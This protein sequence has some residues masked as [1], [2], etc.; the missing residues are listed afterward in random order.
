MRLRTLVRLPLLLAAIVAAMFALAGAASAAPASHGHDSTSVKIKG[1]TTALTLDKGT[2]AVLTKNKVTVKP[3]FGAK[4]SGATL[5]FPIEGGKVD[6]KTLAGKIQHDGG[7]RFSAGGKSL[8]V[9]EFEIDTKAG[10]LTARVSGTHTRV[11][12]LK[13]NL[14]GAKISKGSSQVVV[15][16]VKATLTAEAAGA[17]NKTFG[18]KLF[19]GGLAIG[20]AKV[21]AKI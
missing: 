6:A 3:V 12:L 11:P 10:V 5:S 21:T 9:Q 20:V 7:I 4:A 17:L 15:S 2:A 8:T 1:G 18:V 14:K 13:L 19:K 16:N